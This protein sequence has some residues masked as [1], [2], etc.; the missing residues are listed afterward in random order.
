MLWE[1]MKEKVDIVGADH[2]RLTCYLSMPLLP[3]FPPRLRGNFL[4]PVQPACPCVVLLQCRLSG[5]HGDRRH[6]H[7]YG[8]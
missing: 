2:S 7:L 8:F 6:I 1:R 3:C 4:L 5:R